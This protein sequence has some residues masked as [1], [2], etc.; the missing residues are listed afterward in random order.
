MVFNKLL[1]SDKEQIAIFKTEHGTTLTSSV[2]ALVMRGSTF[3][4]AKNLILSR[5]VAK[6]ELLEEMKKCDS[7]DNLKEAPIA[8]IQPTPKKPRAPRK[9]KTVVDKSELKVVSDEK[10]E[11]SDF[12]HI[13]INLPKPKKEVK[14]KAKAK[15]VEPVEDTGNINILL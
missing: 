12:Q 2:R 10:P 15:T 3:D 14:P 7:Y 5:E 8:E 4:D 11:E 1:D 13:K 6:A 9:A